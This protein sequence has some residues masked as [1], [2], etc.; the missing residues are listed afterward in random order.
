MLSMPIVS[1]SLNQKIL[2][3]ID[4]LQA[5]MGFSGRSEAIRAAI[6]MFIADK[7]DKDHLVGVIDATLF[8]I[9]DEKHTALVSK[10]RHDFPQLIKTQIHN[11]LENQKCLE[12][13]VIKGDA[14]K[15]RKMTNTFQTNKNLD[16]VKLVVS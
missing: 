11:H 1:I 7:K 10:I 14:E 13:F 8:V 15:I 9:H 5:E 12:I 4:T 16:F 3:E 6:R 2:D